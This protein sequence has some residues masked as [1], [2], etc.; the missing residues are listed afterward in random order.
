MKGI[1]GAIV[2]SIVIFLASCKTNS[3]SNIKD[4]NNSTVETMEINSTNLN[5]SKKISIYLPIGY[6]AEKTYPAIYMECGRQ[7]EEFR[8]KHIIDSLTE[9]GDIVPLIVVCSTEDNMRISGTDHYYYE[10]EL[11]SATAKGNAALETINNNYLSFYLNE[12]IPAVES[13][14]PISKDKEDRIFYGTMY[15]ADFGITVGMNN[16]DLFDEYWCFSPGHSSVEQFGMIPG[17]TKFRICWGTK[18]TVN[19][20]DYYPLL[21]SGIRKRGGSITKWSFEGIPSGRNWR[22]AFKKCLIEKF[23]NPVK[24]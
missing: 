21:T 16:P 4:L 22:T 17:K 1:S 13:K 14:Y 6:D 8:Y 19:A 15:S 5:H 20:D 23:G 9:T 18:E 7:W 3:T 12:L 10:A 24:E 11:S 2:L